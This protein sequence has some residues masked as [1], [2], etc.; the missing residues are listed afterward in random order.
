VAQKIEQLAE[1]SPFR[2]DDSC[3]ADRD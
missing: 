1:F 3:E 2:H